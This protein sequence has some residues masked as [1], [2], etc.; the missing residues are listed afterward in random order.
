MIAWWFFN[1]V[2]P[3]VSVY[4][5]RFQIAAAKEKKKYNNKNNNIGSNTTNNDQRIEW[6]PNTL[7]REKKKIWNW[8]INKDELLVKNSYFRFTLFFKSKAKEKTLNFLFE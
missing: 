1:V 3:I 7:K 5:F 6:R 4:V 2:D 8:E